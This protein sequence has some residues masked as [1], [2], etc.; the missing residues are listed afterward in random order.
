MRERTVRHRAPQIGGL[1]GSYEEDTGVRAHEDRRSP[2]TELAAMPSSSPMGPT[3]TLFTTALVVLT[4]PAAAQGAMMVHRPS[5]QA[6]HA[7]LERPTR[8]SGRRP[9]PTGELTAD[10]TVVLAQVK[11]YL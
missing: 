4:S 7:M 8:R 1:F 9:C 10:D 6:A 3:M 11:V 5:A 2:A